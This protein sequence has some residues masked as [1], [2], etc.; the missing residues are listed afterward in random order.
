MQTQDPSHIGEIIKNVNS[1]P[2]PPKNWTEPLQSTSVKPPYVRPVRFP[3][4]ILAD[5]LT[6]EDREIFYKAI[7]SKQKSGSEWENIRAKLPSSFLE[8][9]KRLMTECWE[10]GFCHPR[11]REGAIKWSQI[12]GTPFGLSI[13]CKCDLCQNG[14]SGGSCKGRTQINHRGERNFIKCWEAV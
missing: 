13:S 8:K 5:I 11:I 2:T 14:F 1:T 7:E 3:D 12:K 10:N 6:Y 9:L 4:E